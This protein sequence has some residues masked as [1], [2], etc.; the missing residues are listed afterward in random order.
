MLCMTLIEIILF[1]KSLV[2]IQLHNSHLL[3]HIH[4]SHICIHCQ[5]Y[6]ILPHTPTKCHPPCNNFI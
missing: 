5:Y 2:F 4:Y 1:L 6:Q 3:S